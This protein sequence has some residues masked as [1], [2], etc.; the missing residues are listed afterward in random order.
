M[1]KVC[2]ITGT[3]AEFGLLLPLMNLMKAKALNI[4]LQIIA[5]GAHLSP[6]FGLSFQEIE[7]SGFYINEKVE[8]LLSG[9]T[10][11][12]IAKSVGL[13][14][15]GLSDALNRLKPNWVVLLGDRFEIFSAASASYLQK[16]PIIHLHGGETTEGAIDE[17]F[18]HAIT[19][20]SYLHFTSTEPYRSRVIKM[21][22]SPDRVFN[23]GAIG[24]DNILELPLLSKD[25]LSKEL[26]FSLNSPYLLVTFHPATLDKTDPIEQFQ[27]VLNA[28]DKYT[29]LNLI[30]TFPNADAHSRNIILLLNSYIEKNPS[31]AKAYANLGQLRYL[32]A[33]KYSEA[34]LGNSSSGIIEAPSFFIPTINIG[35]RQKGRIQSESTIN[36]SVNLGSITRAIDLALSFEFKQKCKQVDNPYG[37]GGTAQKILDHLS[38]L[39][40]N[41]SPGK[42][43]HDT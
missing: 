18:R 42:K 26:N 6:E 8:I 25:Q 17:G 4:D 14:I 7:N 38:N 28:L 2:F 5:T 10:D 30:F 43:F 32:S 36:A 21:G 41:Y 27:T 3:R 34:I 12:A 37:K 33:M 39:L 11:S 1:M 13:G 29:H 15:L 31:R 9:D 35:D 22:E 24:L 23:V 19:K 40:Y 16:I 20:L